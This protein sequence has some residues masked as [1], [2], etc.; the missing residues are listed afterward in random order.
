[1][2]NDHFL[3][4]AREVP[5]VVPMARVVNWSIFRSREAAGEHLPHVHLG[6][7]QALVGGHG[8]DSIG[9]YWW[10]GVQVDD[11]GHWGDVAAVNKHG[12]QGD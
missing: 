12:R 3:D 11:I 2:P 10:V 4:E 5:S 8:Q 9:P 1:M 7:G 6:A